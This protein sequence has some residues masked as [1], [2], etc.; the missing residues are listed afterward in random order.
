MLRH[1]AATPCENS[2][3]IINS[4]LISLSWNVMIGKAIPN[5]YVQR[6]IKEV[7]WELGLISRP[8]CFTYF[9]IIKMSTFS[10]LLSLVI[11]WDG[12]KL[13]GQR[14]NEI[15][16][17]ARRGM[18]KLEMFRRDEHGTYVISAKNRK[19]CKLST[20]KSSSALPTWRQLL[21]CSRW[22]KSYSNILSYSLE[23]DGTD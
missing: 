19:V 6:W 5:V 16:I 7:L 13:C 18:R 3:E 23:R 15:N 20:E 17:S 9:Q 11:P 10:F 14:F 22:V 8:A 4:F 12:G 2:L 21:C 1:L